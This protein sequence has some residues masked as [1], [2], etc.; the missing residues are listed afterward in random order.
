MTLTWTRLR[1]IAERF[2]KA[3]QN[4]TTTGTA[5]TVEMTGFLP[6]ADDPLRSHA[7]IALIGLELEIRWKRGIV[8]YLDQYLEKFPELGNPQTISP[9]LIYEEYR[10]RQLYGDRPT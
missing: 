7:L 5:A 2:E 6:V 4:E 8:T 9:K 1:E 3:W 10:V